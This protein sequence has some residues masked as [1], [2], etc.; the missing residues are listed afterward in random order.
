MSV[1]VLSNESLLRFYEGIRK[2]V[3]ADH[4]TMKQGQKYFFTNN[5]IIKK[6]AAS[7]GEEMDR[8]RL[9]YLRLVW[10]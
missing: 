7:L 3:D 2:E 6:Y 8:R 4:Q 9:S 10:L 5:G 1:S